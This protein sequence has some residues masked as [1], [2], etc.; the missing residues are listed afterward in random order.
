MSLTLRHRP[1]LSAW[2]DLSGNGMHK[3]AA[4]WG[5]LWRLAKAAPKTSWNWAKTTGMPAAKKFTLG[6]TSPKRLA[7]IG[8]LGT[9]VGAGLYGGSKLWQAHENANA[10][11]SGRLG[12]IAQTQSQAILR[13][14]AANA[15]AAEQAKVPDKVEAAA[16]GLKNFV[17][18]YWPGLLAGGAALGA[19]GLWWKQQQERKREEEEEE[20]L[21]GMHPKLAMV[22]LA[23]EFPVQVGFLA[24][25][26]E[27]RLNNAQVQRAIEK[28]A[29]ISDGMAEDWIRFFAVASGMTKAAEPI[30]PLV[31]K[32]TQPIPAPVSKVP[33]SPLRS[34]GGGAEDSANAAAKAPAAGGWGDTLRRG[35][36]ALWSGPQALAGAN[37]AAPTPAPAPAPAP[38]PPAPG[39][40]M[41]TVGRGARALWS[42]PQALQGANTGAPTPGSRPEPATPTEPARTSPPTTTPGVAPTNTQQL[43]AN[44]PSRANMAQQAQWGKQL[45][46]FSRRMSDPALPP[47]QRAQA[48]TQYTSLLQNKPQQ[49]PAMGEEG[50]NRPV[51][52]RGQEIAQEQLERER[53]EGIVDAVGNSFN[54]MARNKWLPTVGGVR[55][56]QAAAA[57]KV[58]EGATPEQ[59]A[60]ESYSAPTNDPSYSAMLGHAAQGMSGVLPGLYGTA[61][62]AMTDLYNRDPNM[63]YTAAGARDLTAPFTNM[64]GGARHP[65]ADQASG[66][67][68]QRDV[69]PGL[70]DKLRNYAEAQNPDA[71]M[72]SQYAA[73]LGSR[74]AGNYTTLGNLAGMS[75]IG[76]PMIAG[77]T[78]VPAAGPISALRML[79]KTAPTSAPGL[80]VLGDAAGEWQDQTPGAGGLTPRQQQGQERA[81]V[82]AATG[83]RPVT[84]DMVPANTSP[85]EQQAFAASTINGGVE[86]QNAKLTA[87]GKPPMN[88][89]QTA[90]FREQQQAKLDPIF[91]QHN[92][93]RAAANIPGLS[94]DGKTFDPMGQ[95]KLPE[96]FN[97]SNTRSFMTPEMSQHVEVLQHQDMKTFND[98]VKALPPDMQQHLQSGAPATPQEMEAMKQAGVDPNMVKATAQ[99]IATS[100][101]LLDSVKRWNGDLTKAQEAAGTPEAMRAAATSNTSLTDAAKQNAAATGTDFMSSLSKMWTDLGPMGQILVGG[102]MAV[103]LFGMLNSVMGEG[104]MGSILMGLLGGG[105]VGLGLNQAGMLPQGVS[106]VLN[107]ILNQIGLGGLAGGKPGETGAPNTAGAAGAAKPAATPAAG[108]AAS[109]VGVNLADP[110]ARKALLSAPPAQQDT[111]LQQKAQADPALKAQLLQAHSTWTSGIPFSQSIVSGK[112]REQY[113][114]M[115]DQEISTLM[116]T[117][118]R[119]RGRL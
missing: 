82:E 7:T 12:N 39:G 36:S 28:C 89:Q 6:G 52:S 68:M 47:E 53:R 30:K 9:G 8:G 80:Q 49:G 79:A 15:A 58:R 81:M 62:G 91:K 94:Q 113:P 1:R 114:D 45:D 99:R 51:L 71:P 57:A 93:A 2:E 16:G 64:L 44:A 100:G 63:T 109:K 13:D 70:S 116:D 86:A 11:E 32:E 17:T 48:K 40:F 50:Q 97:A 33:T 110:A 65:V 72:G 117:V 29:S 98:M 35:A 5:D 69:M 43:M 22:K 23:H 21:S 119:N 31:P 101:P 108:G 84:A 78:G 83:Q 14:Q 85:M 75:A 103:G 115:T 87:A 54:S 111:A 92:E 95:I 112:I 74:L 19:G 90:A 59:A 42:G 56:D 60:M 105:A 25:C 4:G 38:A 34:A 107:P 66:L 41:D 20:L 67:S 76:G 102:G 27:R 46:E 118:G 106:D 104:G 18:D 96:G 26:G 3:E 24:R 73:G 10:L 77:A 61:G 37:R 55:E 88:A